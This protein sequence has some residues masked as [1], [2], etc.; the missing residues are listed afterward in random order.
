MKDHK[1]QGQPDQG[2]AAKRARLE[3]LLLHGAKLGATLL[4][5]AAFVGPKLPP[6]QGE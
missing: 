4:A 3:G 2:A 6:F 1:E 5:F